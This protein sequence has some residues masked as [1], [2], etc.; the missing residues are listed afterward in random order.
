MAEVVGTALASAGGGDVVSGDGT[1]DET[2]FD[3]VAAGL[4]FH[5]LPHR[6][7]PVSSKRVV[8]S[9][10][11]VR[12]C[13]RRGWSGGVIEGPVNGLSTD[14]TAASLLFAGGR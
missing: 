13:A 1:H 8:A 12:R 4:G 14:E 10:L 2:A 9:G 5:A 11:T 6:S 7:P 3:E